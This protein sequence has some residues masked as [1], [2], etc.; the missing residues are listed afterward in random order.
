MQIS[1][2]EETAQARHA[3][4]KQAL[5]P[6]R[7]PRHGKIWPGHLQR[8]SRLKLSCRAVFFC[9]HRCVGGSERV[10]VRRYI[11]ALIEI[12]D[13]VIP[14]V[15]RVIHLLSPQV[16]AAARASLVNHLVADAAAAESFAL[17]I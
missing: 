14:L 17:S 11:H 5:Y 2:A 3:A 4:G 8:P 12:P 1:T 9:I 7:R 6:P 16:I 13:N 15:G 10:V